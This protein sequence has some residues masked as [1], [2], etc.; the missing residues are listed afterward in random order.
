MSAKDL[1]TF[2]A[3]SRGDSPALITS[4]Q[5]YS[6]HQLNQQVISTSYQMSK[7]GLKRSD[8]LAC[9]GKNDLE[10]LIVYLAAIRL[11][12]TPAIIAPQ[13]H[14]P[15]QQ[16]LQQIACQFIW[17]GKGAEFLEGEHLDD[18][19]FDYSGYRFLAPLFSS[20]FFSEKNTDSYHAKADVEL[21]D[22]DDAIAS[23]IFTSGSTGQAKAVAHSAHN[24]LASA[25]GLLAVFPFTS[26]DSWQLSLPLFHVSGLAIV[27]RWLA[28][29]ASLKVGDGDSLYDDLKGATHAS[30]VATQL[31]RLLD[32][33]QSLTLTH[34]LLGG[35]A[36]PLE[37]ALQAQERGIETWLGYGMTEAAS[38]VT[39]KAVDGSRGVGQI[40]PNR[41]LK[42]VDKRIYIAGET[43][44]KGNF[45]AGKLQE[46]C[47]DGWFDSGD[48]GEWRNG[49]LHIL[50]RADNQFISG[51]ENVHCE[52]IEQVL[53]QH[54]HIDLVFIVPV[55]DNEFGARP[56]AL[57]SSHQP[58]QPDNY[59]I[60]L[61]QQLEKFKWPI[62]YFLLPS[63]LLQ[64]N[65]IK[66]SR[67][68]V[69]KWFIENQSTYQLVM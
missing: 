43:L 45:V 12:V 29:G 28:A 23:L 17:L 38:T 58:L 57:I 47:H 60:L 37:L 50:G 26:N 4:Y 25:K 30:L 59:K 66:I 10:L 14:L 11:G 33:Q 63:E 53:I 16:K 3:E 35:S 22:D 24:H 21:A 61:Q 2:W 69:A 6:W 7:Q 64:T 42:L 49:E 1:L 27:W 13:P 8:V 48:L 62:D 46:I 5:Q 32:S 9:I 36:I 31:Q 51:G 40:L 67:K 41:Q 52:E 65:G 18:P 44:A 39:A 68:L 54:Q 19:S 20:S 15:L 34:V 56:V 55:L